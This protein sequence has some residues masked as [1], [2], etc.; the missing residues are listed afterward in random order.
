MADAP[1]RG[2]DH[3]ALSV[4]LG[5]WTARGTSYGGTDQT[6]D[7]PKAN[8]DTWLSTHEAEW[9]TGRFFVVQDERADIDGYRF[10]T[11]SILGV[12]DDG[13]YFSRS[14]ENHGFYRNYKVTRD[15]NRWQFDGATE[16]ASVT[17]E[18]ENKRQ[19][20]TW[21]WRQGEIWLPLCDRIAERVD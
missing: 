2:A 16:R 10:D 20:W 19:V 3:D 1:H 7:D 18:D 4:F 13:L 12:N 9:H 21:E 15:G 8:G 17:F 14:F 5:K 11:L 6:A